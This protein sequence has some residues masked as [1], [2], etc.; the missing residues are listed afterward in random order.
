ML[1]SPSHHSLW[2]LNFRSQ[3]RTTTLPDNVYPFPHAQPKDKGMAG[4]SAQAGKNRWAS[5][6]CFFL[7]SFRII[8]RMVTKK[9]KK[10]VSLRKGGQI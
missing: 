2:D 10:K 7:M 6:H 9:K 1:Q 5:P 4:H 8:F 3:G